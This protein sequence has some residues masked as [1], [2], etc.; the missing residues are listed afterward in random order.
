MAYTSES[1]TSSE[2][3]MTTDPVLEW[4][5]KIYSR[6]L[7]IVGDYAG[8]ELFLIEGDSLLVHCLDDLVDFDAG[9]QLLHGV[10][11]VES[12]LRGLISR[13][14]TFHIAFFDQHRELCVPHAASADIREKYHLARAAIIRHLHVNLKLVL[15]DIEVNVFPS[16][17][18]DAFGKYLRETDLFFILC[19]DGTDPRA[20][21]KRNILRKSLNALEDEI[22]EDQEDE[23]RVKIAFRQL[24]RWFMNQR[25]NIVLINGFEWQDTKAI[26]TVLE[27]SR[28]SE[29]GNGLMVLHPARLPSLI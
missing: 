28:D 4:Y 25:Y 11:A 23:L 3:E 14:C 2:P 5:S 27:T 21:R 7:D 12:F 9:F 13:G 18:S 22:H 17:S 19:N 26:A 20:L 1:D 24:I 29:N 8:A 6:R 15:P 10:W 16:V